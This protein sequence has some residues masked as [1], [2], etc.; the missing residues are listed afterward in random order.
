MNNNALFKMNAF[1]YM[2]FKGNASME[3]CVKDPNCMHRHL[4]NEEVG[5]HK[6]IEE[7]V[8]SDDVCDKGDLDD[9]SGVCVAEN[10]FVLFKLSFP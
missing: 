4:V 9:E 7:D 10:T 2:A 5:G 8:I 1:S 6:E 3:T